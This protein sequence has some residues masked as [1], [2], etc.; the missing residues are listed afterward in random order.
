MEREREECS[1]KKESRKE[2]S[3][4]RWFGHLISMY[5]RGKERRKLID[6][7]RGEEERRDG[8]TAER[9]IG[10]KKLEMDW[11]EL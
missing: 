9:R 5:E 4:L 3:S 8:R 11:I 10:G 7:E 6:R 2:K 1:I